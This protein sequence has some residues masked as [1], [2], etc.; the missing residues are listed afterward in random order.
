MPRKY[1]P[2]ATRRRKSKRPSPNFVEPLPDSGGEAAA[3]DAAG[4]LTLD[5]AEAEVAVAVAAPKPTPVQTH[6]ADQPT[7][8]AIK[9]IAKDYSYVRAEVRR[10]LLVAGFLIVSLIITALLRN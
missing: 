9:H 7:A 3:E 1:R 4:A 8:T 2:P 6:A 5:V 10:I